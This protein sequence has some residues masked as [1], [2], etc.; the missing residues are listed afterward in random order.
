MTPS[1]HPSIRAS[2]V[3]AALAAII[4]IYAYPTPLSLAKQAGTGHSLFVARKGLWY[5]P[6]VEGSKRP[7]QEILK[8]VYRR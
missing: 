1:A 7:D 4:F 2:A 6:A 8:W 5:H 3:R